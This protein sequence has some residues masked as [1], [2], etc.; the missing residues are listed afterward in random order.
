MFDRHGGLLISVIVPVYNAEPYLEECLKSLDGQTLN[1]FEVVLVDDGSS[2]KSPEIC[3]RFAQLHKN[4]KVI[5]QKNQGVYLARQTGLRAVSDSSTYVLFLD[6]DDCLRRDALDIIVKCLEETEADILTFNYS[7]S[8]SENYQ[9]GCL[10]IDGFKPGFYR[11]EAYQEVYRIACTGQFN[12]LW[13]KVF[14]TRLLQEQ[15][16]DDGFSPI[17]HG[18]DLL[19]LLPLIDKA[20]SLICIDE[21][22]YFYRLNSLS[23][24]A[25]FRETQLSD[26]DYLFRHLSIYAKKW[27][28]ECVEEVP[29]CVCRNCYWL[30]EN[31]IRSD[32]QKKAKLKYA[33][34]I[35]ALLLEYCPNS[36]EVIH[37]LKL[38]YSVP[39]SLILSKRYFLASFILR[40]E[41][42]LVK[43]FKLTKLKK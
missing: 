40:V 20:K 6:A 17:K 36:K 25:I 23:E 27:G 5:H 9:Q 31:L 4:A 32:L 24:S 30:F 26:L 42:L 7:R 21:V 41:W 35:R 10:K 19:Q 38:V 43:I 11:G 34:Q 29:K 39:L 33:S 8:T 28:Q 12:N 13:S 15:L 16:I 1:S 18:E 22:L 14:S 2:D 37:S 3:D